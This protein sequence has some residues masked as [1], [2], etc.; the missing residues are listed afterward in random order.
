MLLVP[1]KVMYFFPFPS[2]CSVPP[3]T[4]TA[5]IRVPFALAASMVRAGAEML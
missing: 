3:I 4:T 2:F 1:T 5:H